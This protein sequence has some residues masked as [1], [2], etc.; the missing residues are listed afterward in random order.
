MDKLLEYVNLAKKTGQ[1]DDQIKIDLL[2]QGITQDIIDTIFPPP[3]TPTLSP[4]EQSAQ[5]NRTP[6]TAVSEAK[7]NIPLAPTMFVPAKDESGQKIMLIV[8]LGAIFLV[9]LTIMVFI[10]SKIP[11]TPKAEIVKNKPLPDS[12][13][14]YTNN[15]Q[16]TNAT[17]TPTPT[18]KLIKTPIAY[19]KTQGTAQSIS[20]VKFFDLDDKK[21]ID[22]ATVVSTKND[23]TPTLGPW[24]P[25]GLNLPILSIKPQGQTST[26]SLFNIKTGKIIDLQNVTGNPELEKYTTA[27]VT[28]ARWIDLRTLSYATKLATESGLPISLITISTDGKLDPNHPYIPQTNMDTDGTKRAKHDTVIKKIET[29]T[30]TRFVEISP[31]T[32]D[33]QRIISELETN[34]KPTWNISEDG[35]WLVVLTDKIFAINIDTRETQNIC[36]QGCSNLE[37]YAVN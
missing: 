37:V 27:F 9:L 33:K 23:F 20:F 36:D 1:S 18:T 13:M 19:V 26:L 10:F 32:P 14:D 2:A 21:E 24:S 16:P 34:L 8:L 22:L 4:I 7:P 17:P 29:S 31:T 25:D 35:N 5:V 3:A 6:V 30:Y 11:K 12:I 15:D 28:D